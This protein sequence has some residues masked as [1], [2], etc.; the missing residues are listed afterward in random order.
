MPGEALLI[1]G[2]NGSG[3]S[4][5]ASAIASNFKA[6]S[7]SIEISGKLGVLLQN[8]E[9]DFPIS[10]EDFIDLAGTAEANNELI[11]RL[12][13]EEI[14]GKKITQLSVGQ[15]QRV[16]IAQV[17]RLNPDIYLLD[18]PFSAQDE[19]NTELLIE[20]LKSL[21]ANG[22]GIMIINHIQLNLDGLID[23]VL[24]LSR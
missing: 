19:E 5:L 1:T 22:K 16:E 6:D 17:L 21:K 20:I 13:S 4:T 9:I 2:A 18:E 10:V 8:I 11:N 14:R 15:L 7:G 12:I 24:N 23:E 3:K